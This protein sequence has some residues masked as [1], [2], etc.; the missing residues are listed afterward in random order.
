MKVQVGVAALILSMAPA[1]ALEGEAEIKGRVHYS[2]N[3]GRHVVETERGELIT[4][5]HQ[6]T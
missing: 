2:F 1:F 6:Q 3:S 5:L 4:C